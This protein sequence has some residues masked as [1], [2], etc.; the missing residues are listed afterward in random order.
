MELKD[1]LKTMSLPAREAFA[2]K[3]GTTFGH[4]RNVAYGLRPCRESLAIEIDRES[5]AKVTC[6]EL[7]SDVDW[8]HLR[9]SS[10]TTTNRKCG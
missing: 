8:A 4:L 3:C 1:F 6:E 7:R 5:H 9:G 10:L 2:E